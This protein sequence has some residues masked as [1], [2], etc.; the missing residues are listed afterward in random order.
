MLWFDDYALNAFL[1]NGQ[2]Q[3]ITRQTDYYNVTKS[4]YAA[5]NPEYGQ[6]ASNKTFVWQSKTFNL[7]TPKRMLA[8]QV[9]ADDYNAGVI[10]FR[11]YANGILLHEN[12]VSSAKPFRIKN[13]SV[14]HDFSIEIESSTPIRE[15][16]LGETM[17]D[18]LA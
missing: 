14:K 6:L 10:T 18:L 13:H 16:V 17:R 11:V 8:A 7:D 2:V 3:M 9:I 1:D 12:F 4:V 5:F 15:V